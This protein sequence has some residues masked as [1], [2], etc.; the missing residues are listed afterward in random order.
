V[1]K[2]RK[3]GAWLWLNKERMVFGVLA[4]VLCFRVYVVIEGSEPEEE[5]PV[6]VPPDSS[7]P[8]PDIVGHPPPIPVVKPGAPLYSI[9]SNTPFSYRPGAKRDESGELKIDI[10]LLKI[11][12]AGR[13]GSGFQTRMKSPTGKRVFRKE[14]DKIGDWMIDRIEEES[15]EVTNTVTGKRKVL[16]V[17]ED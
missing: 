1:D 11:M 8:V 2:I 15:V 10:E 4:L 9:S 3:F 6:F 13:G 14:G 7:G 5:G 12:P 16:T 17:S